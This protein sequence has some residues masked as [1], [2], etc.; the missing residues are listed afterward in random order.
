MLFWTGV[1]TDHNFASKHFLPLLRKAADELASEYGY[2]LN[3][4]AGFEIQAHVGKGVHVVAVFDP[5]VPDEKVFYTL[6]KCGI[7]YDRFIKGEPVSSTQRLTEIIDT[8][9]EAGASGVNGVVILP[10]SLS[11]SGVFDKKKVKDWLQTVEY[12][13]PKLLAIEVDKPLDQMSSGWNILLKCGDGCDPKWKREHSLACIMSSDAKTYG[14]PIKKHNIG[15]H[16]TF[17]KLSRPTAEGLRQAFLAH[18]SRVRLDTPKLPSM[19]ISRVAISECKFFASVPLAIDF[20]RQ[21]NAIIGGRGTGKSTIL[22]YMRWALHDQPPSPKAEDTEVPQY[23]KNREKIIKETLPQQEDVYV[24]V[25]FVVNST[26]H[27]VTRYVAPDTT[28]LKIGDEDERST[29]AAE[30]RRIMSVQ[31]YSQKQLSTISV[32]I[33]ELRRLIESPILASERVNDNETLL[34]KV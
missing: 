17:I 34:F 3:I 31:A 12:K 27:V 19:Y 15:H 26:P 11:S 7:D 14:D 10:H 18:R 21:F 22:E 2:Q 23:A 29:N 16:R 5:G 1:I 8:V 33:D 28:V 24:R 9:Q 4:M 20:N 30:I 13:N 32:R 6:A 25:D